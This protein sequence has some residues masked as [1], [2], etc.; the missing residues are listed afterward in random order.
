M[1]DAE[2]GDAFTQRK[3]Q[4]CHFWGVSMAIAS[5]QARHND[6]AVAN[7]LNLV[8]I[9]LV[10][11]VVELAVE[12]VHHVHNLRRRAGRAQCRE[13]DNVAEVD[14]DAVV[15]FRKNT[16]AAPQLISCISA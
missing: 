9:E 11:N 13:A 8:R 14:A 7:G 12:V 16:V 5:G 15:A 1:S 10:N 3:R 6:V 2:A 4:T